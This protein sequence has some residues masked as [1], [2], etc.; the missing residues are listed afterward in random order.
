MTYLYHVSDQA[1]IDCF[2]PRPPS[3][4]DL[5]P[6]V[7]LVWAIDEAHLPNFLTPRNTPRVCYS[8]PPDENGMRGLVAIQKD[9]LADLVNATLYVYVFSAK[10]FELQDATAGFYTSRLA[11]EPLRCLVVTDLVAELSKH[12]RKLVVLDNLWPLAQEVVK[13]S[14]DWSLCRMAYAR[15]YTEVSLL[16]Q[17]TSEDPFIQDQFKYAVIAAYSDKGWVFVRHHDRAT[18][19][20]PGGRKEPGETIEETAR[21]EL[22]EESGAVDFDLIPIGPYHVTRNLDGAYGM[23]YLAYIRRFEELPGHEIAAR[24]FSE[25]LPEALTYPNIQ[26]YLFTLAKGKREAME[27]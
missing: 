16:P 22:W 2:Y 23:F 26:P 18:W 7:P 27:G 20:I 10:D 11:Q 19:E 5:D 4:K 25:T 17:A 6:D 12:A 3:R 15:E 1:N 21:R 24:Q 14:Y 8:H 9:H 13:T